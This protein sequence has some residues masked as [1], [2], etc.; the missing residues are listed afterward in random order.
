MDRFTFLRKLAPYLEGCGSRWNSPN[1]YF[2]FSDQA[3]FINRRNYLCVGNFYIRTDIEM[4]SRS[5]IKYSCNV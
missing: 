3:R 5:F 1:Y 4:D 2:F